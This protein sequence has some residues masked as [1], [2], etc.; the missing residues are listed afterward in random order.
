MDE[1]ECVSQK[2]HIIARYEG[3]C[4]QK[5]AVDGFVIQKVSIILRYRLGEYSTFRIPM[6]THC[7]LIQLIEKVLALFMRPRK[8]KDSEKTSKD[9]TM[10]GRR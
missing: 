7:T 4:K 3:Y 6:D 2:M 8:G 10:L 9:F 5:I 1:M